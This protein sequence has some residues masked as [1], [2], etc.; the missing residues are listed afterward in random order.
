YGKFTRGELY[1]DKEHYNYDTSIS[2]D[3]S[4]Y[5]VARFVNEFGFHSLPSIYTLDRILSSPEA[6]EFNSS[7][8]RAHNK[9]PPAGSLEY[10][11][12]ADRGQ[13][14]LMTGVTKYYP[15]PNITGDARALL[16][17]WAYTTQVFQ[18]AFMASQ[19]TY[20]R[21]GASRGENNMGAVY[22]QWYSFSGQLLSN[23]SKEFVVGPLN[24]TRLLRS[25]GLSAI[26][27][28]GHPP[29]DAWLHLTLQTNDGKHTNE[30]FFHPVD[31]KDC[32]LRPTKVLSRPMGHNQISLQVA[33]GGVAAWVNGKLFLT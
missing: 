27:P 25:S 9:N 32:L 14:Q 22:W 12:P 1:G 11:W 15:T 19:I 17:Q 31:L 10:P 29:N 33:H 20:Y 3:I 18:A 5:P 7:V 13:N 30:Q 28:R 23:V 24:S 8:I 21:L 2:F 6:H 4:S 16:A 26:V